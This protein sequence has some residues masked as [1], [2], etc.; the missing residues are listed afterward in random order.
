MCKEFFITEFSFVDFSFSSKK[1]IVPTK[2]RRFP[3][4]ISSKRHYKN[5]FATLICENY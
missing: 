2:K 5:Y 4:K 3:E 1:K